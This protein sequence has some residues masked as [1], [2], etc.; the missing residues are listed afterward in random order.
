MPM[1]ANIRPVTSPAER[2][3]SA[4]RAPI[5]TAISIHT[6]AAPMTTD[7]VAAAAGKMM[8]NTGRR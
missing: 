3:R 5:G 8:S 6:T 4:P 1:I 7:A 2:G